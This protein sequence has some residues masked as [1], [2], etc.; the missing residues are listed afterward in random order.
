MNRK[1]LYLAVITSLMLISLLSLS[2][3]YA[4]DIS[5][6]ITG[7]KEIVVLQSALEKSAAARCI[8]K[9]VD[10][11]LYN[12]LDIAITQIGQ[13]ISIDA[14]L[15]TKE[16]RGFHKDIKDIN[17]IS[18]VIDEMID[19][20]FAPAKAP[21]IE[22][23]KPVYMIEK[24]KKISQIVL[25][26][27]ATSITTS[28]NTIFVSDKKTIYTIKDDTPHP[29]WKAPKID[30]IFRIYSYKDNI[31]ALVKHMKNLHT[32]RIED[33]HTIGH[34]PNPVIPLGDG[35][36]SSRLIIV[37]DITGQTNRWT[38][39]RAITGN[40]TILPAGMDIIAT[41]V[42]DVDPTHNGPEMI[43]LSKSD[44]LEITNKGKTIW[45]GGISIGGL[46]LYVEDEYL[47][48]GNSNKNTRIES[49]KRP[50]RYY[51]PAKIIVT[52]D[53]K[54]ITLSNGQP[55]SKILSNVRIY[56]S[57]RIL[58]YTF[59]DMGIEE[60]VLFNAPSGYCADFTIQGRNLL[61]VLAV[62]KDKSKLLSINL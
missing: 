12:K 38:A 29:W 5:V 39:V 35:L 26:F 7:D 22:K 53:K 41:T 54:I 44:K 58:A 16:P 31:I 30:Q 1:M 60:K 43:S 46:P 25:P 19:V 9:G 18:N 51:L 17:E 47:I 8:S 32:Y 36:I 52:D 14:I 61:Y 21:P 10:T 56:N 42:S 28:N 13:I 62:Y 3:A 11:S 45:I 23:E 15:D 50:V 4:L 34:W 2:D 33:G 20:I 6:E 55:H 57:F 49:R 27:K 48:Q 37:P 40:P 59:S 24:Q